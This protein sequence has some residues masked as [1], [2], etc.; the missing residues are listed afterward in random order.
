I[1]DIEVL[2]QAGCYPLEVTFGN[3]SVGG[4]AYIWS[5]GT[6]LNSDEPALEHTVEYFNPTSNVLT[7]AAVLTASTSAGCSSQDVAYIEVLP[8]VNAHIEGGFTGCAPLEVD[9]LNLSDGAASYTWDFGDGGQSATAHASH[10][11][12][13]TLGEDATYTVSLVAE[14]IYGCTDTAQVS[15]QVFAAPTADFVTSSTQMTYP[16]TTVTLS[17]TSMAGESASHYWTF[18]DGQVSYEAQPEPHAYDT[19]GT[20]DIT[21]EVDNGYCSSV[22]STAIQIVAPSPTIGFTGEGAGCAPLTVQFENLSTYASSYRWEFSDGSVRS[23]DSPV[24]VFNEP[25]VYD[26]T[27]HVEGFDGSAL[28]ESH[29]AVVEVFPTAQAAFSLNPN[30][31]MVPGQPVFFLNLSEGATQYSWDFGDGATSIAETPIHEYLQAGVYDVSLTADNTWGC[32][33]TFTLPEAVLAEEGGMMVFPNAFTPSSTG[34]T[35]G[36]YD[37]NS[38]DNDVFRPMH[39]GIETYELMVFTKW[40]EMIF[41]SNEVGIGWDGYVQGKL[42][43]TD[44]YAWKATA[45]LSN[46]ERLQQLGNVTLLAR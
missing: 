32:S 28:V 15:V 8:Q 13:T 26:V 23:D 24:H 30:H 39:V 14:S 5:Y 43:A 42:A 9:F 12:T 16:A 4:E 3:Q 17:N 38:Y 21:L 46:G 2:D 41:H 22:A 36:Y 34:S 6:G 19:W 29:S 11:F 25:G 31:V 7:Y 40:G 37:A 1:A 27:L 10:V 44:V 35:G 45:T 18:G 33:T 20:Y